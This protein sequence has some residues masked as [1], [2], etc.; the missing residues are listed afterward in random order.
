MRIR[1]TGHAARRLA[2]RGIDEADVRDVVRNPA[3][4]WEDSKNR[5]WVC[6]GTRPDGRTLTVCLVHP[7]PANGDA[8]VKTAFYR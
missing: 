3:L 2:Q 4:A 5:S 6:S 1:I 8:I 7:P